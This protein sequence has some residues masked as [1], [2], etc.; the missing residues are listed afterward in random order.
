MKMKRKKSELE[1]EDENYQKV[2][3]NNQAANLKCC[4]RIT[5]A[6]SANLI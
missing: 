4:Q 2:R 3:T 6:I 5:T 1:E